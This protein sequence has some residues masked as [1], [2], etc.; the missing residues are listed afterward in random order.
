LLRHEFKVAPTGAK[1][2][3]GRL[4]AKRLGEG[5]A[6]RSESV[7]RHTPPALHPHPALSLPKLEA[8]AAALTQMGDTFRI[9]HSEIDQEKLAGARELDY[10]FTRMFAFI[11]LVLRATGRLA[12]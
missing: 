3:A 9:R 1:D 4:T 8:E 10:A 7:A 2:K 11:S 6:R 12:D 5:A